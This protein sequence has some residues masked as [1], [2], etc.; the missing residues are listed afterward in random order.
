MAQGTPSVKEN[1]QGHRNLRTLVLQCR[2]W[3]DSHP[4]TGWYIAVLVTL[5]FLISVAQ[6]F[7]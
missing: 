5:N 1:P 7:H 3:I 6:L 4:R 2:D